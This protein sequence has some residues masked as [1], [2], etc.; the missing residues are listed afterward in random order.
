MF[1]SIKACTYIP[2]LYATLSRPINTSFSLKQL[3]NITN[4]ARCRIPLKSMD[5]LNSKRKFHVSPE[6]APTNG[7]KKS[8]VGNSTDVA[9]Q[10]GSNSNPNSQRAT[11]NGN[12]LRNRIGPEVSNERALEYKEGRLPRPID[13]LNS[14]LAESQPDRDNIQVEGAVVHWFRTDLRTRDNGALHAASTKAKEGN[15]PLLAI[16]IISP[17][18]FEAHFVSPSRVDFILRTLHVLKDDLAKLDIPLY[19]ET[20]DDRKAIPE[21][22]PELLKEWGASHLFANMELEVDELRRDR[23]IVS[24]CLENG[25]AMNILADT[26][27]VHPGG[28]TTGSGNQYSV[29]TPWFRSWVAHIHDNPELLVLSKEPARNHPSA[30]K[31]YAELFKSTLP[32]APPNKRLTDEE[33]ARFQLMWPAGEHEAHRRLESFVGQRIGDYEEHR[34]FPAEDATSSLS[35]HLACGTLSART[36]VKTAQSHNHT[37]R[38]N[39][40][41]MG[42]QSWIREVAWRDFY[43]HVLAHWPYIWYDLFDLD[44][45]ERAIANGFQYEQTLQARILFH[46]V[47]IRPRRIRSL[48]CRKNGVSNRRRRNAP[49]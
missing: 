15:V 21:R 26:C 34:N 42:I 38:L 25:I 3:T 4:S 16:Y 23:K 43:R 13:L 8:K 17:Q 30:R 37:Q 24:T 27:V 32:A 7:A 20:A 29:Y 11:G 35:V 33:K 9:S 39:G 41:D 40:G 10:Q 36:A 1:T 14:T 6:L 28:L 44:L 22:I 46:R 2:I 31:T 18:D 49:T 47:G 19:V 5:A 48:V 12:D 45:K